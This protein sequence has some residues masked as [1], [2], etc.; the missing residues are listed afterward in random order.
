MLVQPMQLQCRSTLDNTASISSGGNLQQPRWNV[1]SQY[2]QL[3][4]QPVASS[5]SAHEK[6]IAAIA[7]SRVIT[8][9]HC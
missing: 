6:Q 7:K 8:A 4:M 5:G 9:Q 2:A 3:M 1:A